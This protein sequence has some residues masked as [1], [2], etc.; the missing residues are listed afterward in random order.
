MPFD[1]MSWAIGFALT[2]SVGWVG[3]AIAKESLESKLEKL[4][5]SWASKL[6]SELSVEPAALLSAQYADAD[7]ATRP[8]LTVLRQ[9]LRRKVVPS[10]GEWKA[11]FVEEWAKKKANLGYNA[12][13]FF[14]A[15]HAVVDPFLT[16]LADDVYA[17]CREDE[18][19]FK[20]T[21]LS[22]LEEVVAAG[23]ESGVRALPQPLAGSFDAKRVAQAIEAETGVQVHAATLDV[24]KKELVV[25]GKFSAESAKE[26]RLL[27]LGVARLVSA[28][29]EVDQ[30]LLGFSDA[31]SLPGSDGVGSVALGLVPL[32]S[33]ALTLIR[34]AQ[35]IPLDFWDSVEA[36][37]CHDEAPF[38]RWERMPFR[39][40]EEAHS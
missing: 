31:Q 40:L 2:K 22:Y 36:F 7:L 34:S 37:W 13:P 26:L 29:N 35:S 32:N 27:L 30:L 9:K 1:P 8:A 11:G 17:R 39:R 16:Q 6:P 33:E 24:A 10:A 21:V 3:G 5:Q 28:F 19:L 23:S 14:L 38:E 12:Q 4:V 15:A 18:V 25:W 20:G